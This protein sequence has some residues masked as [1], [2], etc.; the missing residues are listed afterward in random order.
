MALISDSPPSKS[1]DTLSDAGRGWVEGRQGICQGE[2]CP[3]QMEQSPR[4]ALA[5]DP[6]SRGHTR[7][8]LALAAVPGLPSLWRQH[9]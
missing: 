2:C 9:G 6:S 5:K 8:R 7:W 3:T 4:M 1:E